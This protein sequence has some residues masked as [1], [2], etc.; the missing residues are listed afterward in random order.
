MERGVGS[1]IRISLPRQ[2]PE[3]GGIKLVY[4]G[5]HEIGNLAVAPR[6]KPTLSPE[7]AKLSQK[8]IPRPSPR[9][10]KKCL[11]RNT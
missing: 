2:L 10:T 1:V 7:K 5:N 6:V 11:I 8:S 4:E 3:E 9:L